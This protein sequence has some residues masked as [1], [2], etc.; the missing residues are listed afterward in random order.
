MNRASNWSRAALTLLAAGLL[1]FG[2]AACGDDDE[3]GGGGGGGGQAASFTPEHNPDFFDRQEMDRQLA[4]RDTE[5]ED[6]GAG[7]DPWVQAIQPDEMVD[8]S[9]YAK[10]GPWN[11][12][13]S[14]ASVDNPWRVV[15]WQTMQK[16]VEAL[17]DQIADFRAV[18]AEASDDKQI[19]DIQSL[20]RGNRCDA[21]I[22][23]PNTT[24]TLTP[25]VEQACETGIPVI[26]FD[27]GVNTDCPV[28]FI[29][30]IGGYAFG[31]DAAE[32]LVE[33]VEPG[34]K[35]LA[36]RILPGVDVL[37]T[38]WS[39][40]Q[41]VF[42]DSELEI[43]GDEQTEGDAAN[44]KQIVSDYI[45]R[46]GQLD[47]IWMDAGATAVAAAEAFEDAGQEIPP[48]TGEDQLDFLRKWQEDD[49]TAIAPVYSN[50]QWRTPI[51]AATL[52]LSGQEVP[53]E[54]VL[55]QPAVTQDQ[56]DDVVAEN[57]G[58]PDLHY[59]LCGCEDL[60]GY[61]EGWSD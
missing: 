15:G 61:P 54:W 51:I 21:L 27:R 48:I 56:L 29:K 11:I 49:L 41:E 55:P 38:R 33:N 40:A 44:T 7:N 5:P 17:G 34:G 16:Q 2:V 25:A 39:A 53:K 26:V 57:E 36:L 22:V 45:A 42:A 8:T 46:E 31:A 14:N 37:E 10:D 4:M 58:L 12:C 9:E 20:I 52:I 50:Y 59:A 3:G 18:D 19:S 30:P 32:F 1:A 23:S 43:V 13:F 60:P 6:F 28:T 35:I 24:A 47:G